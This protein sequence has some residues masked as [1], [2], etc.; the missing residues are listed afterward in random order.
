MQSLRIGHAACSKATMNSCWFKNQ[1]LSYNKTN[2]NGTETWTGYVNPTT[3]ADY[4]DFRYAICYRVNGS[5][6]WANY[7]GANYDLTFKINR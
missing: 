2:V 3:A 1:P 4:K 5:E 6:F 7:H